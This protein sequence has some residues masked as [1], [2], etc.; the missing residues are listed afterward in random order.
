MKWS[1]FNSRTKG[2]VAGAHQKRKRC[3]LTGQKKKRDRAYQQK[4]YGK[5]IH[6]LFVDD[7]SKRSDDLVEAR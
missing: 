1:Y 6:V 3:P 7:Y 4:Y 5:A 2:H